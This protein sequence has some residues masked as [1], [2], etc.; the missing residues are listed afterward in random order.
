MR[1]RT[2]RRTRDKAIRCVDLFSGAGGFS[3]AAIKAGINVVAAFER[4]VHASATYGA[5]IGKRSKVRLYEGDISEYKPD[6]IAKRHFAKRACDIVLGGPPCQGF[7]VHR[8]NGAGIKDPRNE[9]LFTYFKFVKALAPRIFLVENVPGIL[10]PRHADYLKKFIS[11][12]SSAGYIVRDPVTLDARDYGV[13]QRRKRVFILGVRSDV[14]LNIQ[15][16]PA[17]T[18]SGTAPPRS[19]FA[20]SKTKPWITSKEI[21]RRPLKAS[22]VNNVHMQPSPSMVEVFRSTPRNGG[23]RRD[24]NRTLACHDGHSGHSDVYGRIN[25]NDCGPTMTTACINPSKGRFV[26]PTEHHGITARHAARFQTFPD[27]FKFVGGL[28]ASGAQIGNAVPVKLGE[29]LL[30]SLVVGLRSAAK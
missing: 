13:P 17:P 7:S 15:W 14:E 23:S 16:P 2:R 11:E 19:K 24:S 5:N 4:D 27:W 21:F 20:R 18:H 12:A 6:E 25:P 9:L 22:D 29:V 1:K 28:M 26:H 3:L 30:R 8:I 10:W